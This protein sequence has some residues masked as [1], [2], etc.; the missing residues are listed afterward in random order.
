MDKRISMDK[1]VSLVKDGSV[2]MVGGFGACGSPLGII[3]A[4][5]K[6]GVK[7][8]TLISN[9][10]GFIDRGVG[11]MVVAKQFKKVQVSHIGTNKES[12]RQMIAGEMEVELIPQGTLVER[13]RAG[14]YGLGGVLTQTGLGTEIEKGKQIVEV[15]GKKYLLEK[16]LRAEIAFLHADVADEKGNLL[17]HGTARNFN[18]VM[19]TAAD[20]VVVEARKILPMGEISPDNIVVPGA[21]V[22]YIVEAAK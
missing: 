21:L 2:I 16:P 18:P 9:D 7:N 13:I 20:I 8:L 5:V 3:D 6:S 22:T 10:T 11:L 19:A 1:A 14:G 12:G 4:L 17:Y 15:D